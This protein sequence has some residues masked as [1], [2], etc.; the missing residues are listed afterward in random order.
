[1]KVLLDTCVLSEIRHPRGNPAVREAVLAFRD[2][3][4]FISVL[5]LGELAKGVALLDAGQRQ[6]ELNAWLTGLEQQYADRILDITG[7]IV[8]VWGELTAAAQR[9]GRVVPATDGL[10]AATALHHGLQVMTRNADDFAPTGV[11]ILN[12]W[13]PPGVHEA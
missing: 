6:Q 4:L 3:D 1:M 7:D 5:T 2:N 8:R 12:P 13:M 10:I 9:N 11:R